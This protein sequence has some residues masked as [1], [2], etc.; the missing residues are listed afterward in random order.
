MAVSYAQYYFNYQVP[1]GR[2]AILRGFKYELEL[3]FSGLSQADIT[4]TVY[5]GSPVS[6][7]GSIIVQREIVAPENENIELGQLVEDLV[8][9]YVV[10]GE[11]QNISII[12]TCGANYYN[13]VD[14]VAPADFPR[15]W[16][17]LYGNSLEY[18]GRAVNFEPGTVEK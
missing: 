1:H 17:T 12:I 5:T 18:T 7:D 8:P 10:A 2:V 11:E 9:I 6:D 15:C 16:V 14:V 3:L 13:A 4:A